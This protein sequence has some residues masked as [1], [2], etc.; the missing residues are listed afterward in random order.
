MKVGDLRARP[1]SDKQRKGKC[2]SSRHHVQGGERKKD[3]NHTEG[4][5]GSV[6]TRG[7]KVVVPEP[8]TEWKEGTI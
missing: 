6:K 2:I 3:N 1:R 8:A 7:K 4:E 5:K